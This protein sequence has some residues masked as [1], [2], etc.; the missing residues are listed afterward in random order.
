MLKKFGMEATEEQF[1]RI[2]LRSRAAVA[3]NYDDHYIT[4]KDFEAIC[5]GVM[6]ENGE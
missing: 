3:S 4:F 2:L 1:Q 5:R 6:L